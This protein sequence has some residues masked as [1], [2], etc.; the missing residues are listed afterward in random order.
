MSL[1]IRHITH[2]RTL[3]TFLLLAVILL[4]AAGAAAQRRVTPVAPP[5]GKNENTQAD[6][7]DRSRLKET[8]DASGNIILIDTVAGREY[9]DTTVVTRVIGMKY[10]RL[11]SMDF[12]VNL[13]DGAMRAL[14]QHYG[15]VSFR[16]QLSLHNRYIPSVEIGL[17]TAND[18]PD[19][20]N[21]TFRSPLAPFV[22][23]G[24]GYN[25]FYNSNPDYRLTFGVRYGLSNF[26]YTVDNVTVDEGYWG[27]EAHFSLPSQRV[28]AGWIEAGLGI[29]VKIASAVSMGW[30]VVYH[31]CI[32]ESRARYGRPMIIPGYGKRNSSFAAGVYLMYTIGFKHPEP[33]NPDDEQ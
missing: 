31:S 13:W 20:M 7:F 11:E 8:V 6:S 14:G 30:E 10:P 19:G 17:G 23:I 1:R 3:R 18:T 28:T 21:Y 5:A 25:I 22:K 9:A 29:K 15:L 2:A 16:G 26:S 12:G 27:S 33:T 24:F 32:H 4:S